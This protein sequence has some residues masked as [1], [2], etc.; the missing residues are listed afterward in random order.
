MNTVIVGGGK[1]CKTLLGLSRGSF[2]NVF[3]MDVVA[4]VDINPDAPGIRYARQLGI[5][6][7]LDIDSIKSL[8]NIEII[9]ELTGNE[10][11]LQKIYRIIQPGMRL[12]DHKLAEIFWDLVNARQKQKDQLTALRKMERNVE[13]ERHF[14][15]SIFDR[16]PDLAVV[17]DLNRN[18]IKANKQFCDY[19]EISQEE[20]V[21]QKCFDILSQTSI[22]CDFSTKHELF[23]KVIETGEAQSVVRLISSPEE[24][25]WEITHSPIK[26]KYGVIE[27]VLSTWH[28]ITEKIKLTRE[29]ETAEQRFRSF[30]HSALDW[31][32][33]KDINGRYVIV[34]SVTARAM[35]LKPEEFTG[36]TPAE[37][38]PTKLAAQIL[39]NDRQVI[40]SRQ[41]LTFDEIIE[42]DGQQHHFSTV[43]FPLFDYKGE[44]NGVCT[45]AR[46]VTKEYKL[47]EQLI[48]SEKLAAIGKLAAGVAHEINN[49]LTGIL[50]YAEDISEDY[51][52]DKML[53]DD[54]QVI[55]RETLRCRDIVRNLLDYSR[56]DTP[57]LIKATPYSVIENTLKLVGRLP[58]FRDIEIRLSSADQLPE[59]KIDNQQIQQVLLNL[60]LNAAEAMNY[61]GDI[62]IGCEFDSTN[63]NC[64]LSVKDCGPGISE[65][66]RNHIFE[67]FFSTKGTNGL[68]LAVSWGI[69]E[70]HGGTID[71]ESEQGEG[72][73][74]IIRLPVEEN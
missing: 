50:A 17:M 55:I 63:N 10:E 38:L 31:I 29:I 1:I 30:I 19:A 53:T 27:S 34:N 18:I 16:I 22:G 66:V 21:G 42:I 62:S 5:G 6:T 20:I 74:F 44:I 59:V 47:Q 67:P 60:M 35:H 9:I 48:Q 25:H 65:E 32:S 57:Q 54:L 24:N 69:I 58:Q 37:I 41:H 70:R 2:L 46:D 39:E 26:N 13:R 12:I 33:I 49:P 23:N 14:L 3:K 68:G 61:T 71:V 8:E 7:Y 40:K 64:L 56:Q 11:S 43:R 4:V 28:K 73:E 45:I 72:T 52:E 36:K 51:A 15:Q